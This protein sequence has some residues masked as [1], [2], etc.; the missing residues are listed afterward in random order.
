[1]VRAPAMIIAI[2]EID[3]LIARQSMERDQEKRKQIAW[4][5]DKKLTE[6]AVRP[7]IY[8][9]ARSYLLAA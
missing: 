5:I 3:A 8:Y 6:D 9:D 2:S 7:M 4:E 1:M